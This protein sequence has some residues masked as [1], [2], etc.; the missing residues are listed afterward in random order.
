MVFFFSNQEGSGG[1]AELLFQKLDAIKRA[2]NTEVSVFWHKKC[3]NADQV[4]KT[5]LLHFL[6]NSKVILLVISE[7]VRTTRFIQFTLIVH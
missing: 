7:K 2:N 5:S 1:F 6:L 4:W 3:L